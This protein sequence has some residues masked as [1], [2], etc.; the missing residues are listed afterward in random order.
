MKTIIRTFNAVFSHSGAWLL[1]ETVAIPVIGL[2]GVNFPFPSLSPARLPESLQNLTIRRALRE[3]RQSGRGA[4]Q[5][6]AS[7]Q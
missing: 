7:K 3:Y 5:K 6:P 2:I 1:R 4:P